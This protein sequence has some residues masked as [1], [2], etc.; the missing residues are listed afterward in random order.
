MMTSANKKILIISAWEKTLA[1]RTGAAAVF[2]STGAVIRTFG[3]I[4]QRAFDFSPRMAVFNPGEVV[5][6]QIGNSPDWP[7]VLLA[8]LRHGLVPL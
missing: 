7:S 6:I 4:E 3:D 2:S 5:A 8:A 1:R